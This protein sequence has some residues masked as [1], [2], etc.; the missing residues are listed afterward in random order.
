MKNAT[1]S[2]LPAATLLFAMACGPGDDE[3]AQGGIPGVESWAYQLQE[4]DLDAVAA[5]P[6][7]DLIVMD[8]SADGSEAGR[9]TPQQVA[10][11]AAAGKIPVAYFS[12]GEAE[13]YRGYWQ[14]SWLTDPPPWLGPENPDWPGNYKVRFWEPDW[15]AIVFDELRRI[16]DQGFAGVYL[17]IIDAYWYWS[18]EEG[19]RPQADADM[20]ALVAAIADSLRAWA[21]P[22]ALVIPQNG[23][24]LPV[25]D[26]VEGV[27]D[28]RWWQAI[29]GI[30]VE[31]VFCPGDADE[32][33]P[34]APDTERLEMLA[35]YREHGKAVLSVEYLTQP[36]AIA[37]YRQAA[38]ARGFIPYA[39]VRAL[40]ELR[41]GLGRQ[42]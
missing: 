18:E 36:A 26:D 41:P 16:A 7:F 38:L 42:D 5:D 13:D 19:S 32:D 9:W 15:Q 31:D 35:E 14:A 8:A 3:T 2:L 17:D 28:N 21:G 25:E 4:L 23:E 11:I 20:A 12:I 22:T 30:G 27:W 29:D 1:R 37:Q 10:Q 40:D 24:F 33:N 6:T 39:T 34:I